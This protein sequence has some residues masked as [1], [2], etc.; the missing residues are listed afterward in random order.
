MLW[1]KCQYQS[2][3]DEVVLEWREEQMGRGIPSTNSLWREE[4]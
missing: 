4:T 3:E 1:G 2:Q